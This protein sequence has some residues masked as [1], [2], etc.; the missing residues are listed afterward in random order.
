MVGGWGG[1]V[2]LVELVWLLGVIETLKDVL[3]WVVC[4]VMMCGDAELRKMSR[5]ASSII[6]DHGV[7]INYNDAKTFDGMDLRYRWL[8]LYTV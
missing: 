6:S 7:P 4:L 8:Q 2:N 3:R 5:G 1:K